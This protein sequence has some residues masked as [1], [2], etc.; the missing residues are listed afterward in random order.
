[1]FEDHLY[2]L[3]VFVNEETD[4][5]KVSSEENVLVAENPLLLGADVI[6]EGGELE[7]GGLFVYIL[8]EE[9]QQV[10]LKGDGGLVQYVALREIEKQ[11]EDSLQK[12][13]LQQ[14]LLDFGAFQP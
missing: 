13:V 5:I 6:K 2:F 12:L 7:L 10:F 8:E 14:S 3:V 4:L 11:I 9:H 1:M